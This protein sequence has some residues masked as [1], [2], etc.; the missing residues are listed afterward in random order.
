MN[1]KPFSTKFP[2]YGCLASIVVAG[3]SVQA[4]TPRFTAPTTQAEL[5]ARVVELRQHYAPF[6]RSLPEKL[7]GRSRT[8]MPAQWKFQFEAKEVSK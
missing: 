5:D 6:L 8:A 3:C 1:L 2:S 4:A 7:P